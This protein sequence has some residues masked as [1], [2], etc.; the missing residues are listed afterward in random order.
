[1][2]DIVRHSYQVKLRDDSSYDVLAFSASIDLEN[3][4]DRNSIFYVRKM[5]G[6]HPA[7]ASVVVDGKAW[8]FQLHD[9]YVQFSL[10]IPAGRTSA[11]A[12][13]YQDHLSMA[14]V[15]IEKASIRVYLLRMASDFRDNTLYRSAAGR[16]VVHFY[17]DDNGEPRFSWA[18]VCAFALMLSGVFAVW[19]IR[20]LIRRRHSA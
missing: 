10:P 18:P 8:P 11:V 14:S 6:D 9:G 17:Y 4:S 20:M 1:L 15:G 16:M 12:I 13:Q 5:E 3:A 7:I 19:R 2:G